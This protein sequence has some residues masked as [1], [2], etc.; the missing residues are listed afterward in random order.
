MDNEF[1]FF[2]D[3]AYDFQERKAIANAACDFIRDRT[4]NGKGIGG[5]SLGK[6][7]KAYTK[8]R[9]FKTADK[10]PGPVNLTLTGD[11]LDSIKPL[12]LFTAGRIVIGLQE[13]PE[14]D[15]S[16]W[17]EEKGYE[18]LGLTDS[19][20]EQVLAD[21]DEPSA[22]LNQILRVFQVG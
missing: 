1:T 4:R 16:V 15:K 20:L 17:V 10:E 21:F 5:K 6:Y 22:S 11:M 2:V 18:F 9:D 8:H 3:P 7:S 12:D 13:G 19:E 14:A